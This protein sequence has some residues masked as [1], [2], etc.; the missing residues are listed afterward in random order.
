MNELL[1]LKKQRYF[2]LILIEFFAIAF[3]P[4]LIIKITFLNVLCSI[5]Y[6][7]S[8]EIKHFL[9]IDSILIF[10]LIAGTGLKN[11]NFLFLFPVFIYTSY[12]NFKNKGLILS[13]SIFFLTVIF[14]MLFTSWNDFNLTKAT[15]L[16]FLGLLP[17]YIL[18]NSKHR[19]EKIKE[20]EKEIISV[21]NE[22]ITAFNE[23]TAALSSKIKNP[24]SS[25][26]GI[27]KLIEKDP[28]MIRKKEER[29]KILNIIKRETKKLN[30][31][32]TNFVN[33]TKPKKQIEEAIDLIKLVKEIISSLE[34]NNYFVDK[35][36]KFKLKYNAKDSNIIIGDIEKISEA[37][38]NIL[39]NAIDESY[40]SK[41][42]TIEVKETNYTV[43][44]KVT[45]LGQTIKKDIKDKIFTPFFTTKQKGTGLGLSIAKSIIK[46]NSGEINF[47]SENKK[48]TFIVSF[49]RG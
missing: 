10:I 5:L 21:V 22:K 45:N 16:I 34:I 48:T 23:I 38:E 33:F 43:E 41:S 15:S 7:V 42:I 3:N 14:N 46:A 17:M 25:L 28:S 30:D 39:L 1:K 8:K 27:S 44:L 2:I 40:K 11:S 26:L 9:I 35:K 19:K 31:L 18:K 13:T 24:V 6:Y 12:K 29:D 37:L 49:K 47:I 32:S 20:K 4:E 36:L